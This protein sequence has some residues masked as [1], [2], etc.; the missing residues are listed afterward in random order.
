MK[1]KNRNPMVKNAC[2][3]R[4]GLSVEARLVFDK[5]IRMMPIRMV[6]LAIVRS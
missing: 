3:V 2:S 5:L 1:P 6:M 4:N